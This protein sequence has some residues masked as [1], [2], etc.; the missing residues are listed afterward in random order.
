[1]VGIQLNSMHRNDDGNT[2]CMPITTSNN[3]IANSKDHKTM[4]SLLQRRKALLRA[5]ITNQMQRRL[6]H[7]WNASTKYQYFEE[8]QPNQKKYVKL[9]KHIENCS[10]EHCKHDQCLSSRQILAHFNRCQT[11]NRH[12]VCNFCA[13]VIKRIVHESHTDSSM[14][15]QQDEIQVERR[16]GIDRTPVH[17]LG[18]H[19]T[20][21]CFKPSR[22]LSPPNNTESPAAPIEK[23]SLPQNQRHNRVHWC[24]S[25]NFRQGKDKVMKDN[26]AKKIIKRTISQQQTYEIDNSSKYDSEQI[27]NAWNPDPTLF[28][29]SIALL[30]LKKRA[31]IECSSNVDGN[32]VCVDVGSCQAPFVSVC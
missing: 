1:M 19:K 24:E 11:L 25:V 5:R 30:S 22:L 21:T 9:W 31:C 12:S 17:E 23:S 32:D 27:I 18:K 8:L 13:P 28:N 3:R 4:K 7:L 10:N 16:R 15:K 29:V 6:V 26:R 2:R 14:Y 20:S